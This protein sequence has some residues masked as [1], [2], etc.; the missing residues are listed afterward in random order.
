MK[1]NRRRFIIGSAIVLTSLV[2]YSWF[3]RVYIDIT[4]VNLNLGFN[5]RILHITD[6]HLHNWDLFENSLTKL[7][8]DKSAEVD[9]TI[10]TGDMYDDYTPN[11]S[12]VEKLLSAI[13]SPAIGV[14]GN[15]EH[16]ASDKFPISQGIKLYEDMGI[17]IL[18]NKSVM[19][20]GIRIGGIDWYEDIDEIATQYL[21]EIGPVDILLSHTPDIIGLNPST[22]L[23]VAGH[24]HGG[25]INI[26]LIGPIWTPSKYG[27]KYAYGLFRDNGK[28]MYVSRGVGEAYFLPIRF[29]CNREL[30]I[31]NL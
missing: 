8:K 30:V 24:T 21:D 1:I 9:L 3:N 5:L 23:I 17:K 22:K 20:K 25:Q 11:L 15:H 18:V 29:N 31:Y 13:D 6:A 10:L 27:V 2:T 19:F 26:P 16:W 7:I 28:Y 4:E 14:L 12:L